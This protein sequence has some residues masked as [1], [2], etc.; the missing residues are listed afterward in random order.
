MKHISILLSIIA[1]LQNI[2]HLICREEFR[3]GRIVF[4]TSILQSLAKSQQHSNSVVG[5]N[6]NL[7]IKNKSLIKGTLTQI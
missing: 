6:I 7:L 3:V 2:C 4:S 1:N 5:K